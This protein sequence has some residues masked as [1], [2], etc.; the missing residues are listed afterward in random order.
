M[1]TTWTNTELDQTVDFTSVSTVGTSTT[2]SSEALADVLAVVTWGTPSSGEVTGTV[3]DFN[4][5]VLAVATT[6]VRIVVT[7]A[8]DDINPD[9]TA[10]LTAAASPVGTVLGG[11]GTSTLAI[12][13]SASGTFAVK[14]NAATGT[15]FLHVLGGG[16]S[17]AHV[18][19]GQAPLE[20]TL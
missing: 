14:V 11:S 9:A 6:T 4:G 1:A 8:A 15:V 18:R 3:K 5:N 13:T 12:K 7:A 19:S 2:I 20:I 10:Y 17:Q 16:G